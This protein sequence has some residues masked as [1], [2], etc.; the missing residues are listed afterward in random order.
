MQVHTPGDKQQILGLLIVKELVLLDPDD[1][2]TFSS[3]STCI[4]G[5]CLG[6]IAVWVRFARLFIHDV[7][8][9]CFAWHATGLRQHAEAA[10]T[11][12]HGG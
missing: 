10:A 9:S 5:H 8:L 2:V 6:A 4:Y 11:A 7:Q 3:R 1:K 12:A